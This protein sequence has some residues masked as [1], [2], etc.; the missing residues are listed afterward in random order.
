MLL[1]LSPST[2]HHS[3]PPGLPLLGGEI[4]A[5][6]FADPEPAGIS[7]EFTLQRSGDWLLGRAH[8]RPGESAETAARRLYGDLLHATRGHTL[9]RIWN[10]VPHINA[11]NSAGLENYRAF[12]RG[13]ALAFRTAFG[14]DFGP[15]LPAASAVGI[16]ADTLAVSFAATPHPAAHFENPRQVPAY[17]YPAEHGP[18]APSF[19]RAT[20]VTTAADRATVFIS[21][22]AAITGHATVAPGDT[23]AQLALT[24]E[25]LRNIG[26]VCG[27]GSD[28]SAPSRHLTVYLRHAAD[29]P[30]VASVLAQTLLRPTDHA[31]YVRS[32][33]CRAALN[34]EIEVT[35]RDAPLVR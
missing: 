30:A 10:Y 17:A 12:C 34:V 1:Q 23:L 31:R 32:D 13:R 28:L 35:L 25:N 9:A 27:V 8:G 21:G 26:R 29:Y 16:D 11:P 22:T 14:A 4:T 24:C 6:L 3:W 15:R 7:G 2:H 18:Q 33:I 19:A 20:V 5:A